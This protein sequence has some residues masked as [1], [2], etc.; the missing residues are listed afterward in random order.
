VVIL[1][2]AIFTYGNISVAFNDKI[3]MHLRNFLFHAFLSQLHSR[4][5]VNF[6]LKGQCH[7]MVVEVRPWSGS[8]AL[9]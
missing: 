4:F 5:L 7:K 6:P 1:P 2:W 9:N 8:L 3:P